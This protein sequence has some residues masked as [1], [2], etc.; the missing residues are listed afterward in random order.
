MKSQII[1]LAAAMILL[2]VGAGLYFFGGAETSVALADVL[3]KVEQSQVFMYKLR[4]KTTGNISLGMPSGR[5]QAEATIIISN[6]Y[7]M[8]MDVNTSAIVNDAIQKKRELIYILPGEK[9]VCL[10]FPEREQYEVLEFS[11]GLL[12]M[13]KKKSNDPRDM[14]RQILNSKYVDMVKSV[15][16]GVE[17]E[18][19]QTTVPAFSG[20]EIEEVK[21]TLWVDRK[22]G[23][24]VKE[25][26]CFKMD[27][28]MQTEW[29]LY[30]F[31]WYVQVNADEFRPVIPQDYTTLSTGPDDFEHKLLSLREETAIEA[32]R[33]FVR[34]MGR[35]PKRLNPMQEL[36][37]REDSNDLTE[38]NLI[39]K[40]KFEKLPRNEQIMKDMKMMEPLNAL[41]SCYTMLVQERMEP[42]YYG[43][44]VWP[45]DVNLVLMRWKTGD[46]EYRVIYGNLTA[47]TVSVEKLAELE[48]QMPKQ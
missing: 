45:N 27:E 2:A 6:E 3:Q 46:N 31:R 7:G 37:A 26:I 38:R 19:F 22:T 23:L 43:E 32:F 20:N 4:T 17:V 13:M 42:A 34:V 28:Q 11:K 14:L 47:E 30:D 39:W 21:V 9:K 48:S 41:Y 35:Y 44:L 25:E 16:D 24:P 36:T 5:Q 33:V 12:E 18:G 15:I 29:V 40:E 1:K 10:I 8:K